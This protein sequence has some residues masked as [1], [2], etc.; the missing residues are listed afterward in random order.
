MYIE[1]IKLSPKRNG[2]GY[3]SSFSINISPKEAQ[4]CGLTD[5]RIIKIIDKK[6]GQITIKAKTF[7]VTDDDLDKIYLLEQARR[8]EQASIDKRY[9][10]DS[11][12][13]TMNELLVEFMDQQSGK[14]VNKAK[15]ELVNFLFS[16]SC[17]E[18]CDLRLLMYLGRD[19]NC[20]MTVPPGLPRFLDF[21]DYYG[22]IV[23]GHS[24]EENIA[25]LMEKKQLARYLKRGMYLLNLPVGTDQEI[26][27]SLHEF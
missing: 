12:V 13:H 15:T 10:A 21:Y 7:C 19:G 1:P 11:R 27:Y 8:T 17:E 20:N 9:F 18:V 3:T 6:T 5:N 22:Y 14:I 23:N 25:M 16:L 24:K 2:K 26:I 4:V